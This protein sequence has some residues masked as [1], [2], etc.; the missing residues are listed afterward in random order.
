[1]AAWQ[2]ARD[3]RRAESSALPADE[4]PAQGHRASRREGT[5][6]GVVPRG[7]DHGYHG[8]SETRRT[9]PRRVAGATLHEG[10]EGVHHEG[11]FAT[12][13]TDTKACDARVARF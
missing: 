1:M 6:P 13:T 5:E 4:D 11:R 7:S 9:E 10:H 8:V 2:V 3:R 12:G